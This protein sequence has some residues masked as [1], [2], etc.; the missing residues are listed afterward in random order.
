M[1]VITVLLLCKSRYPQ[2][3]GGFPLSVKKKP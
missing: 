1:Y 3:K 2:N